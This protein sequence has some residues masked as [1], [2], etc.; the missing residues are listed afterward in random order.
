MPIIKKGLIEEAFNTT[1]I[2]KL[3]DCT[4]TMNKPKKKPN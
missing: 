4:T 1:G 2:Q 3:L